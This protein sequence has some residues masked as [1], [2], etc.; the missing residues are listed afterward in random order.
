VDNPKSLNKLAQSS[1]GIA[2]AAVVSG[3]SKGEISQIAALV[4]LTNLH[5]NLTAL[6]QDKAYSKYRALPKETQAALTSYFNPK[7]I[8]QDK[9][10]IGGLLDSV[11]TAVYYGGGTTKD[12]LGNLS[13]LSPMGAINAA[14]RGGVAFTKE[15]IKPVTESEAGQTIGGAVSATGEVLVRPQEKL[16][17]QPF[18]AARLAQAAGEGG[19]GKYGSFIAEGFKELLPGGEDAIPEDNSTNFMK[20]WEKASDPNNIYDD[21]QVQKINEE[22]TPDVSYVA[23]LLSSEQDLVENFDNFKDNPAVIDLVNRYV[24]GEE[25]ASK[26]IAY[27][28]ARYEKA[29][30]SP[31]R[32]VARTMVSLFPHEAERAILG[33]GKAS[34]F[35]T[36]VSGP[37]DFGVTFGLDPLIVGGKVNRAI[38]TAKYGFA[39]LGENTKNFEQAFARPRVRKYWDDA[40]LLISKYIDGD[41]PTKAQALNRLQ[42]R[43]R[44]I[45]ID[46]I[47]DLAKAKVRNADDALEFFDNGQRLQNML[48]GGV[49]FAGTDTLIPRMTWTRSATNSIKDFAASRLGTERYSN[50]PT[51]KTT[52]DFVR[53]FSDDPIVWADKIGAEKAAL[54]FTAKDRSRLGKIDR[55]VRQFAIAPANERIISLTDNTSANQIFNLARTVLDRTSA[56]QFRVAWIGGTQG[57]KLLAYKGLLKTLGIGMGLNLSAEGR[58]ILSKI[59]DMS[60]EVYSVSQSSVDIGDIADILKT[61]KYGSL[62]PSPKGVRKLVQDATTATS[63]EGKAGRLLAST[64]A[65]VKEY[66]E[67]LKALRS[68]K[69]AALEAGQTTR[70]SAIEDEIKI[71]GAKYGRELKARKTIKEKMG[72]VPEDRL[73]LPTESDISLDTFNAGQTIDGTPRAIRQYQLNDYRSLPDFVEWREVAQRGGVISEVFG[74]AT[75]W[76]FN[77]KVTDGWSFL[78]LYPRLGIRTTAEEVGMYGLIGGANGFGNY[79]KA[80]KVSRAIRNVTPSGVSGTIVG[81]DV[82]F[83]GVRVFNAE[84]EVRNLGFIYDKLFSITNKHYTKEQ[85]LKFADDPELLGQA[86]ADSLIKNRFKPGF[87]TTKE[88]AEIAEYSRDF[89]RFNGK[90]I[91]DD[92][93]GSSV[94]AERMVSAVEEITDSLKQFGP[95]VALN[96]QNQKALKGMQFQKEF[97]EI[98][99]KNDKFLF[100]WLLEINNTVGKRNGK[101]GNIVLWNLGKK[102][103][104]VIKKLIDYIEGE[105]NE[106]AKRF[107]IYAEEGAEGLARNMYLDVTYPLRDLS[108]RIN[109]DLVNGIRSKGG[110]DNF[111]VE[112]LTRFDKP[113]ARPE[114]ILGREIVPLGGSNA[115]QTM[116][117]VI[118]NGYGWVGKQ[119]ALLDREPI[120]LGNYFMFR[121]QLAKTEANTKKNLMAQGMSDEGADIIARKQSHENALNLA[122]NRTLGFVDNGDVRTNLAYSLRTLG[123][124]YRATE[125]FYRRL[126]RLAR[127]EKRAF[128]RLA[129]VNQSFEDSGFVHKDDKGEMYFTYPGDNLL[130]GLLSETLGKIGVNVYQPLPVR[131]GG[132]VK[133]LTPSLDPDSQLPRLSNP[134]ASVLLDSLTNL[135]YIGDYL[136]GVE[137]TLTGAYNTDIP[138][139]EK[140]A[141][142]NVKRLYNLLAG[143][144]E[145]TQS[146]FSSIIKGM[147]LLVSTNNGPTN[148]AEID[149]FLENTSIQ[150]RNVDA[151]KLFAGLGAVAS[152]QAFDNKTVPKEMLDAGVFTWSSEYQKFLKKY[153]GDENALSKALVDFAKLYPD[154]L[155][156]TVSAT[157]S[158]TRATWRKSFEAVD[159]I[160]KNE[161]LMKRHKQGISFFIPISGAGDLEAYS[162][163][164]KQGYVEN[165]DLEDFARQVATAAARNNFYAMSDNYNQKILTAPNPVVKRALRNE[166]K[167]LKEGM[168]I[169]Y[170]LLRESVTPSDAGSTLKKEALEDLR[171][172]LRNNLA[173]DKQL[174]DIFAAMISEY[175]DMLNQIKRTGESKSNAAIEYRKNARDDAKEILLKL[176]ENN[177][178]ARALF[179][180]ILDPLIGE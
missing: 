165:K 124:Y 138:A 97:T 71:V 114:S 164:K 160:K 65:K 37:I 98:S 140:A 28:V 43:Y 45:S 179:N 171:T 81:K 103:D 90:T 169:A 1:P 152:I 149:M 34:A 132:Y 12:L 86:V 70:A 143:S 6:P 157:E 75:N 117:R 10:F 78:N 130:D 62:T 82:D 55:V 151:V 76:S 175:D 125:D 104:V 173:P 23:R 127:Y 85:L 57:Q 53:Q 60:R 126:G 101:F 102:Q 35:F 131:F 67:R 2:T 26:Q 20:Y 39:K 156:Y 118:N 74:K 112:D 59:D 162:Y 135:P 115:E 146:R 161:P 159:F 3:A 83:L 44:E 145:G 158:D 153:D 106:I 48:S 180:I 13:T 141:P 109:M 87:L 30:I 56:G 64:N 147:R 32:D 123:R 105:G 66:G 36:A 107:A 72:Q 14:F 100:N 17:K 133:M 47:D 119:I 113:F 49:G 167:T 68:D 92:I 79:I 99:Y 5:K 42:S 88:G 77:R 136:K 148:A 89:A 54:G 31:G 25:E 73:D 63:A 4:D 154:K 9:G 29:K 137:K 46:V 40:G 166:F 38:L 58:L 33:D 150:A 84:K 96:V 177:E 69:K 163:L 108:G 121:K 41:L 80:R 129:I 50:L 116:Y 172:V 174:G 110:M 142:A 19:W 11:K 61:A 178:N 168:Y 91:L 128:V 27:G 52:D 8:E 21:I 139:W 155:A 93:N 170:P 144:D 176:S 7:Y 51:T 24:S 22:I 18:Q 15:L 94:R 134:F 120:T 95:S 16:V 111:G 122:R